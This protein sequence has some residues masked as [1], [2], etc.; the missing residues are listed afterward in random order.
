M[1]NSI[2]LGAKHTCQNL[3]CVTRFYDLNKG[4]AACPKCG[5]K[6]Q[7]IVKAAPRRTRRYTAGDS[8]G[9]E[10][11]SLESHMVIATDPNPRSKR[12]KWK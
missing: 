5:Q 8:I 2:A 10:K 1:T 11:N 6:V 9:K 4:S 3:A 7:I 12:V